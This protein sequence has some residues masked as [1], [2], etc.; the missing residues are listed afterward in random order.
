MIT[1][2]II[3]KIMFVII[4]LF[5]SVVYIYCYSPDYMNFCTGKYIFKFYYCMN[6]GLYL[7]MHFYYIYICISDNICYSICYHT[8]NYT[9][10]YIFDCIFYCIC[11][12]ICICNAFVLMIVLVI[13]IVIVSVTVFISLFI[14]LFDHTSFSVD[15]LLIL[16]EDIS[17]MLIKYCL[18]SFHWLSPWIYLLFYLWFWL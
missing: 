16:F 14:P 7:W 10:I 2:T 3:F 12:C 5:V 17:L 1:S 15:I 11:D 4:S 8:Q 18:W 6:Q 13:I 9:F